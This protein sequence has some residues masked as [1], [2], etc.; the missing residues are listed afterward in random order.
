MRF[1][2]TLREFQKKSGDNFFRIY[3]HKKLHSVSIKKNFK[4]FLL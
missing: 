4:E 2:I 1:P 3:I